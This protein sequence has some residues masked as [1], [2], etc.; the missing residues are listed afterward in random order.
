MLVIG[1]FFLRTK[2]KLILKIRIVEPKRLVDAGFNFK[3]TKAKK[4]YRI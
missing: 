4:D 2:P 1:D 3:F